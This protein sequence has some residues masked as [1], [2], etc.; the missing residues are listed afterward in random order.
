M[1]VDELS[2][3]CNPGYEIDEYTLTKLTQKSTFNFRQKKSK[4]ITIDDV[5]ETLNMLIETNRIDEYCYEIY[6]QNN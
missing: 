4:K 3:L 6:I 1:I 2:V 5:V